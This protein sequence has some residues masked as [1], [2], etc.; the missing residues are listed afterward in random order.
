MTTYQFKTNIQC[1]GCIAKVT[2]YLNSIAD[3]DHWKVDTASAQ[4][5]LT[6]EGNEGLEP[7]IVKAVQA[8]GYQIE[9]LSA[10]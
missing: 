5:V 1:D 8:A 4:K 10:H 7:V 3:L 2:P 6:L 9:G